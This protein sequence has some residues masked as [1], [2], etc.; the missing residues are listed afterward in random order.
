IRVRDGALFFV[1]E[2]PL[3]DY[4]RGV[5]EAEVPAGYPPEALKAMAVLVRTFALAHQDR[6]AKE[7]F[8]LCDL[9]HCQ[10]YAGRQM[11]Y[12]SFDEAVKAT[13]GITLDYQLKLAETPYHSTC[14]GHTSPFHRVFGGKP[15]PYLQG[16]S[17][18]D[19]CAPSPH[20][21][22]ESSISLKVLEEV[23][24]KEKETNPKGELK[25]LRI[26]DREENGRAFS[27]T[28]EGP[29]TFELSAQK[30]LSL[31]GRYLGWSLIKSDWFEIEV[32]EGEAHFKG[33]GLGHGVGLC[34]WGARGLAEQGKSAEEILFHYYPGTQL[35]ERGSVLFP[36]LIP[37]LGTG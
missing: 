5:L 37:I 26:A 31:V 36:L 18:G 20:T 21:T 6:H 34:Q 28:M 25:N 17:D 8:E 13:R 7:G 4:V 14:G 23:L 1:E 30:F 3:E 16:V 27:I 11:N 22:W 2:L 35:I 15:I 12:L 19:A 10:V 24:K 29:R 33:R 9:T 32:K